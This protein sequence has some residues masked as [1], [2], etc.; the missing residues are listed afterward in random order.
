MAVFS[1]FLIFDQNFW[2]LKYSK[3]MLGIN[4][5]LMKKARKIVGIVKIKVGRDVNLVF[6]LLRPYCLFNVYSS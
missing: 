4:K 2:T 3:L 1:Q 6:D 5:Q